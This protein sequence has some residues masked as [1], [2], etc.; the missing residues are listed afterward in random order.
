MKKNGEKIKCFGYI[1]DEN[2]RV[3]ILGSMPSVKSLEKSEYYAHPQ[4]R[5][6]RVISSIAGTEYDGS[7]EQLV[8]NLKT[9]K[10]ALWDVINECERTGSSDS[11]IKAV[12][13]NDIEGLLRKYPQIERIA[14]NGAKATEVLMKNF[15]ELKFTRL[16]STS[17]L[18]AR[19]KLD[20]LVTAYSA[21]ITGKR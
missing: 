8:E 12:V 19:V 3:L 10:I 14:T 1:A 7:Y 2:S 9:L 18:N 6:R 17:P 5:F 11:T 21:F 13:P 16:P 20:E 4:N 15:P